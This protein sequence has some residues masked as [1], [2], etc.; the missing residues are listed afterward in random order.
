VRRLPFRNDSFGTVFSYSVLQHLDKTKVELS[1]Q[2][3]NRV[4]FEG[5]RIIIELPNK[6]GMRNF[7]IRALRHFKNPD[8]GSFDVRYW[9]I[10]E[11]QNVFS[12]YFSKI[13]IVA[14]GYLTI[15]P[16]ITDLGLLP[17]R[18]KIVIIFSSGLKALSRVLPICTEI[19]DSLFVMAAKPRKGG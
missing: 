5:G 8:Y 14:D 19:A 9:G 7:L 12:R 16:Q 2:D 4:L 18:Y 13:Q 17:F 6:S 10:R 1:L 15:N 11:A 3:A